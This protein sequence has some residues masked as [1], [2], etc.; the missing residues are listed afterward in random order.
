MS[1]SVCLN[2]LYTILS[3]ITA[4]FHPFDPYAPHDPNNEYPQH[5]CDLNDDEFGRPYLGPFDQH[6]DSLA[7][8]P[9]PK[10]PTPDKCIYEPYQSTQRSSQPSGKK[11]EGDHEFMKRQ[12]PPLPECTA[13]NECS[14]PQRKSLFLQCFLLHGSRNNYVCFYREMYWIMYAV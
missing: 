10:V 2:L 11:R 5:F 12:S 6:V 4:H 13:M 9:F 8:N 7:R 3:L 1:N 14:A